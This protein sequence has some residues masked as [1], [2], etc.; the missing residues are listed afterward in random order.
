[1]HI[2]D[3]IDKKIKIST[4]QKA[5][6]TNSILIRNC[7]DDSQKVHAESNYNLSGK[8]HKSFKSETTTLL[9][10]K[11]GYRSSCLPSLKIIKTVI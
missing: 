8:D 6:D 5:H 1:M 4:M 2:V 9:N 3:N 10:I 7:S 11:E